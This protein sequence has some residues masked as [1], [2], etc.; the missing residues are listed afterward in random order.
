MKRKEA[1]EKWCPFA[2]PF[3]GLDGVLGKLCNDFKYIAG[4]SPF[5]ING[6]PL[7]AK[8]VTDKC[9]AWIPAGETEGYCGMVPGLSP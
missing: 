5:E 4:K 1:E 3:N 7:K 2:I 6:V 9:M 8:C